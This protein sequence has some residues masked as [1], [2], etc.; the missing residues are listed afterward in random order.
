MDEEKSIYY[1]NCCKCNVYLVYKA[2][3][4]ACMSEGNAQKLKIVRKMNS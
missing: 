4:A 3:S 2:L 1:V